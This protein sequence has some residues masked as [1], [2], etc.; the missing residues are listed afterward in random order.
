MNAGALASYTE[1][2]TKLTH[3][4]KI[5]KRVEKPEANHWLWVAFSCFGIFPIAL[6]ANTMFTLASADP[7]PMPGMRIHG[8]KY[9]VLCFTCMFLLCALCN[10]LFY[11]LPTSLGTRLEFYCGFLPLLFFSFTSSLLPLLFI[12]NIFLLVKYVT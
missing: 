9:A 10:S 3:V 12:L 6:S 1:A 5:K 11:A 2:S 4:H 7:F 8:W